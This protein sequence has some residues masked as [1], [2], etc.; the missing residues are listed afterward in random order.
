[1]YAVV[2]KKPLALKSRSAHFDTQGFGLI[3]ARDHAPI[4][5]REN[6]DG[7]GNEVWPKNAFT[8]GKE[9]VTIHQRN[10]MF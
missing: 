6:D 2:R 9:I 10:H 8:R 4:I 1:M 7:L 5:V 3:A